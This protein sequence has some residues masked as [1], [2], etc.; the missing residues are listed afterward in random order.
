M[1][2]WMLGFLTYFY[3]NQ[4]QSLPRWGDRIMPFRRWFWSGW[5]GASAFWVLMNTGWLPGISPLHGHAYMALHTANLPRGTFLNELAPSLSVMIL[6]WSVFSFLWLAVMAGRAI[7][8]RRDWW[9]RLGMGGLVLVPV[10]GLLVYAWG[11]HGLPF[12]LLVLTVPAVHLA[13]AQLKHRIEAKPTYARAVARIKRGRYTEA[14]SEI[15]SQLEHCEDDVEGWFMLADMYA[16]HFKELDE[17]D[18]TVRELCNQP[19]ITPARATLALHKLADWHLELGENPPRAKSALQEILVRFPG[20][21]FARMARQRIDQ[22]PRSADELRE[23]RQPKALKLPSLAA[24]PESVPTMALKMSR[25]EA[26]QRAKILVERLTHDPNLPAP[27]EEL[28][29]L[30]AGPLGQPQ[31]ALDQ[32]Q[33]LIDNVEAAAARKAEWLACIART[34]LQTPTGEA[35]GKR[36]LARILTDFPGTPQAH[37]ARRRLELLDQDSRADDP[38]SS[39]PPAPKL[40]VELPPGVTMGKS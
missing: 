15:I 35:G 16:N 17:A 4:F 24:S 2:I 39:P 10:A 7:E 5:F 9:D 25:A 30:L 33:L 26:G 28:A 19:N 37:A 34:Q 12:A 32:W 6:L 18:R 8:N 3:W 38:P 14:E 31:Q 27:R 40:K 13:L 21:H 22:L 11:F 20:S 29:E 23:Q 1:A 36:T